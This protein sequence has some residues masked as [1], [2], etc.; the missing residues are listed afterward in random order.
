MKYS[1][2]GSSFRDF[3]KSFRDFGKSFRDF[4]RFFRDFGRIFRDFGRIFRDF[5]TIFH[6]RGGVK[7]WRALQGIR[8]TCRY[9]FLSPGRQLE[10]LALGGVLAQVLGFSLVLQ[11]MLNDEGVDKCQDRAVLCVLRNTVNEL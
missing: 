9:A 5:G 4:G 7:T 3:G 2:H 6:A 10:A 1:L 11:R 8:S